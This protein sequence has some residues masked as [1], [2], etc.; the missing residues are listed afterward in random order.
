AAEPLSRAWVYVD[1]QTG[2]FLGSNQR[3][4][5][6]DGPATGTSLYNGT[7]SFTADNYSGGSYRLRQTTDGGGVQT[8]DLNNGT[9][10]TNATDITSGSSF[11]SGNATG[12]Q[13]HYG[14]EQTYKYFFNSFGRNS[15]NGSG[16][17]LRSYVSYSNNYVNAFWDGSRMTYGDG[18]GTSYGPLVSLDITGHEIAHGVTE[19]SANLAY[20]RESG[21]L[22]ESFSDIFGEMVEFN[23]LG[24]NDWQMGTDIGIGGSGALRSMNNPNAFGD[25]DTYGG[26]FWTT[27]NCGTPTQSNDYCGVHSNSGVQNK[28][29]YILAMGES[30]T[31]D[32]GN[33][34][35]VTGLGR[36]KAGAIAYR[37]LTQYLSVNSTFADARTGAIQ[38]ATDLYGAGSAEVIATTNAWYAVGVGAAYGDNSVSYCTSNGAS[39]ADEY[40]QRVQLNTINNPSG[41]GGGYSNFTSIATDLAKSTSYTIT[42]TPLWTGTVYAE[43]YSVWIDYNQDGDFADAGEQVMTR[44]AT[45]TTPISASFTVPST[46]TNGATR[47]RVSMKYNGIPTSCESFSYG[48]VED[49]T[50]NIG[51]TG[52]DTQ[53]PTAPTSLSASG[54]TQ[55]TTDLSWSASSDNVGVTGYSVYLNGSSIGTVTGTSASIT[56]L[57]A[58]TTYSFYVTATDLAGNESSASNTIS[59]T[60]LSSGGG[61]GST[62][63]FASYF[64]TGN[65]GWTDG[66]TDCAR[67]SGSNAYE[68][69]FAMRLRDNTNSSVMTSPSINGTLYTSLTVEFYFRP[70]SMENGEDFWLQINTGSGYQTV[71]SWTVGAGG[72]SNNTF[73]SSTVTLND[74]DWNFSGSTLLRFRNDA[75]ADND[76][77]YIDAVVVTGNSPSIMGGESLSAG[78]VTTTAL[79]TGPDMVTLNG[80]EDLE[81]ELSVYPNPAQGLLSVE[82]SSV[83]SSITIFSIDGKLVKSIAVNSSSNQIDV[84]GLASGL[85]LLQVVTEEEILRTK[86]RRE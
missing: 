67:I 58:S 36:T 84:S 50:V 77:I 76:Y 20:Q 28:W 40:I 34:Y 86:F 65:D 21:A 24:T 72:V 15:Y 81:Q 52:A 46:A 8:Y 39:V 61:G 1:A 70:V 82:T 75:S 64:E 54:T 13:A 10:Y 43:G 25:P 30:G 38:A 63:L 56:G 55:T 29:F 11:F 12:V 3:I 5:H 32:L 26:S 48:E 19:F 85:Y 31:N 6:V 9:N 60:T 41:S 27:P 16:G 33:A 44:A 62:Q 18:N 45:T 35:S 66:G 59:V 14:A 68:G 74:A 23:A 79:S 7:V 80:A 73:Y 53:A 4:H 69:N 71:A 51:A 42:I 78:L 49:Y 17:I 47:M 22:N 37:N 83:A 57:V 2:E